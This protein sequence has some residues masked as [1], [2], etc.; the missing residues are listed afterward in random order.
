MQ[1]RISFYAIV[2]AI[3]AGPAPALAQHTVSLVANTPT[4]DIA[5]IAERRSLRLPPLDYEFALT[6]DC[7]KPAAPES[8]TVT[9]ADT[10]ATLSTAEL[11]ES[12]DLTVKLTVPADQIAPV[13]VAGFCVLPAEDAGETVTETTAA[14]QLTLPGTLS[15]SASLRCGDGQDETIVYATQL[16]DVTLICETVPQSD[17][18]PGVSSSPQTQE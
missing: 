12:A 3:C 6:P 7:M 14:A 1:L 13:T 4:V 5:P 11:A 2:V 10:K 15:A 17:G 18:G 9:I 16:L 8:V